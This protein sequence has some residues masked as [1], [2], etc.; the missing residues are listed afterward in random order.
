MIRAVP[1]SLNVTH[2]HNLIQLG[3][4]WNLAIWIFQHLHIDQYVAEEMHTQ[5][6]HKSL[7]RVGEHG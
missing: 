1:S 3:S 6:R 7:G 4:L 5:L 2:R